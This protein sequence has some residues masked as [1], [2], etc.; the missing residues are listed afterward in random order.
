MKQHNNEQ[1]QA[2]TTMTTGRVTKEHI[3]ITKF[4][5]E[6]ARL[7]LVTSEYAD[8]AELKT[9]CEAHKNTRY[10]PEWL[11]KAYEMVTDW[12][13]TEKKPTTLTTIIPFDE[14]QEVEEAAA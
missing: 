5:Q 1:R 7:G 6:V 4:E 3:S 11:L 14:L 10:I 13:E 9:W 2:W 8:S 12:D